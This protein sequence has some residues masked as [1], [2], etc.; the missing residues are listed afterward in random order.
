MPWNH[1]RFESLY[2]EGDGEPRIEGARTAR[3]VLESALERVG[4]ERYIERKRVAL[5]P[6]E[7]AEQPYEVWTFRPDRA[8]AD[9]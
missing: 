7:P 1:N 2:T 5:D 9:R 8:T 3:T 6:D 4:R